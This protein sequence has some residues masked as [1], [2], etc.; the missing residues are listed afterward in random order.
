MCFA[1][2][3]FF[4]T[5][6]HCLV[7]R[8]QL[9]ADAWHNTFTLGRLVWGALGRLSR[10]PVGYLCRETV[11]G[12]LR[13]D[14]PRIHNASLREDVPAFTLKR[15]INTAPREL[16]PPPISCSGLQIL[17]LHTGKM[18][19]FPLSISPGAG[20][21]FDPLCARFSCFYS[22]HEP[23]GLPFRKLGHSYVW[24]PKT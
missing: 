3:T 19:G 9:E 11:E 13:R 18:T 22:S 4:W 20:A 14:R 6:R 5:V 21:L 12:L 7:H 23:V 15:Y 2:T 24:S 17:P 1:R 10:S 8:G 16:L